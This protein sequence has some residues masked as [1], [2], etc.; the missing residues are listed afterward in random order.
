MPKND[1]PEDSLKNDNPA[2][3]KASGRTVMLKNTENKYNSY[4]Y[5]N[6]EKMV[7]ARIRGSGPSFKMHHPVVIFT[8]YL[9]AIGICM[10]TMSP[11]FIASAYAAAGLF[12]VLL[13]GRRAIRYNLTVTAW[14]VVL[15]TTIN[16]LF[17]HNGSTPLFYAGRNAVTREA[18][19]FGLAASFVLVTVI[20][21]FTTFNIIITTE[22]VLFLFGRVSPV[23]GLTLSMALRFFP[24]LR[25][26]FEQIRAGQKCLGRDARTKG[27]S[28]RLHLYGKELS[29][30]LSWS[31][32]ASLETSDSMSARG[33]GLSGRTNYHLF[34]F[35]GRDAILLI[36]ICL[37]GLMTIV[38]LIAAPET[39]SFYPVYRPAKPV[40]PLL[41]ALLS[42][43]ALLLIP[44]VSVIA[45]S[46]RER[47]PFRAQ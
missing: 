44:S 11:Y 16:A 26:R 35:A 8:F 9:F 18:I 19:I 7:P 2:E 20:I 43:T 41:A 28:A 25:K 34:R 37:L 32:E 27:I 42:Y 38:G 24:L 3:G 4:D 33:Y 29:I 40:G 36:L 13:T 39:V 23:L 30:L 46:A 14:T 31:L 10:F 45:S 17:T 15:M 5:S 1:P 22:K 21:W 47:T 12:S 6:T